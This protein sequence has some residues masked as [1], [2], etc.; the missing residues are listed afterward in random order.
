[1]DVAGVGT[2]ER[3]DIPLLVAAALIAAGSLLVVL[4]GAE[5][6]IAGTLMVVGTLAFLWLTLQD[7]TGIDGQ[8]TTSTVA[9]I[10]GSI[11]VG[12][13]I[14]LLFDFDGPLGA[15]LFLFGAIGIRSSVVG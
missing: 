10:L 4:A 1:M 15:A 8:V 13:D 7:I 2:F 3:E 12:F 11:L 14:V 9:M 5:G 6:L